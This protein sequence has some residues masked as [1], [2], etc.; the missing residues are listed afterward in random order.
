MSNTTLKT[1]CIIGLLFVSG[2]AMS[3]EENHWSGLG[4][5]DCALAG[6]ASCSVLGHTVSYLSD[7]APPSPFADMAQLNSYS[8]DSPAGSGGGGSSSSYK[9]SGGSSGGAI[10]VQG[11]GDAGYQ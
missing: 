5:Q 4:S 9:S 7:R 1:V 8:T 10:D 2:G 6:D 3:A 11:G